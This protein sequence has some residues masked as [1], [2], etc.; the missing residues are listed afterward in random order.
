MDD[1]RKRSEKE[2]FH[3]LYLEKLNLKKLQNHSNSN[4]LPKKI[5]L[6]I[7]EL[8]QLYNEM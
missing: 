5:V 6:Q 2:F 4:H 3:K 1:K 8:Q 7:Y